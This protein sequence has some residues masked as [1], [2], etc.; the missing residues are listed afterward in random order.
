MKVSILNHLEAV[1]PLKFKGS[2][3][4]V[5]AFSS[6]SGCE[7]SKSVLS[8]R[9]RSYPDP[10]ILLVIEVQSTSVTVD[11]QSI[12]DRPTQTK[13]SRDRDTWMTVS[14]Q[15]C[16]LGKEKPV[17]RRRHDTV[18]SLLETD[19]LLAQLSGEDHS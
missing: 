17:D 13:E 11:R 1:P 5:G 12:A 14:S 10:S 8:K 4:A 19:P 18:T 7:E 9:T 2:V 6:R 3:R 15:I 16:G